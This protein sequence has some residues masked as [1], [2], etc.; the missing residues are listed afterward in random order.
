MARGGAI[1]F[2]GKIMG[3]L[4]SLGFMVLISRMAGAEILGYF[5]MIFTF[6]MI[7]V[8]FV[9][10]GLHASVLKYAGEAYGKG[11][12]SFVKGFLKMGSKIILRVSIPAGLS[13]YFLA[14]DLAIFF[15]K[16]HFTSY[17][18]LFG[19]FLP[20]L[21]LFYFLTESFKALRRTDLLVLIQSIGL[22]SLSCLVF[23]I[24]WKANI[25]ISS[26]ALSFFASAFVMVV[27]AIFVYRRFFSGVKARQLRFSPFARV[28]L[29][30]MASGLFYLFLTQM[31]TLM[32]GYFR[33]PMEVGI[34]SAASRAA[35]FVGFGLN[36]VNYLFP[37]IISYLFSLGKKGEIESLG[38]RSAR[39]AFTYA[40][41]LGLVYAVYPLKI[42]GI[43]GRGFS[44]GRE[45]LLILTL[46]QILSVA[47]G[48]V[49]YVLSMTEHQLFFFRVTLISVI[50]NFAGNVLLIPLWGTMGAAVSTGFSLIFSKILELV[51]IRRKLG[52]WVFSYSVLKGTVL[53][54]GSLVLLMFL[55]GFRPWLPLIS[56]PIIMGIFVL[57]L[58][59]GDDRR[60]FLSFLRSF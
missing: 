35:L 23:P 36:I 42:L 27:L 10:L 34:Y 12:L 20:V 50:L 2:V 1:A 60:I 57:F 59:D 24:L 22:F 9:P 16:P 54:L 11:D 26:P 7:M 38:R 37:P 45:P 43:F 33:P 46:A 14:R 18:R 53:F 5:S 52:I 58:L 51:Y 55:K 41:I 25:G 3:M 29:L 47:I 21:A 30:L 15:S 44:S 17:I 4:L 8:R 28:S 56:F 19:I 31:D 39:W 32:V 6:Y 49:G 40:L 13:F 48:S